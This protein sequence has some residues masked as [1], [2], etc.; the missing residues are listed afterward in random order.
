MESIEKLMSDNMEKLQKLIKPR[1]RLSWLINSIIESIYNS[2]NEVDYSEHILT[3]VEI[4][5][6]G[7][8]VGYINAIVSVNV[9][10]YGRRDWEY[11]E[12][13]DVEN[14]LIS[15]S[16]VRLYREDSTRLTNI[17]SFVHG[18][19]FSNYVGRIIVC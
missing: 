12:S 19:L 10:A 9:L 8:I 13:D 1:Q 15:I 6:N 7:N 5:H 18:E 17:E 16:D 3:D 4:I 2:I 11:N 14:E